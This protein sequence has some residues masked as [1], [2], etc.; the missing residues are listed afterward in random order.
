MYVLPMLMMVV[1]VPSLCTDRR[2]HIKPE[3]VERVLI[4]AEAHGD[5]VYI[6]DQPY[7]CA[8]GQP[9]ESVHVYIDEVLICCKEH[10]P[11]IK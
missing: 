11:T 8:C 6:N 2:C 3:H 4:K 9:G 10:R 1:F 7:V 5:H